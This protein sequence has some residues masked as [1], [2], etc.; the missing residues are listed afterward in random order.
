MDVFGGNLGFILRM[1]I[2]MNGSDGTL[3]G[4]LSGGLD[5]L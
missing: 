3:F 2:R 1:S 5:W 4:C